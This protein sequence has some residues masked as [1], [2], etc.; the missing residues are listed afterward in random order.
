MNN[1]KYLGY[2]IYYEINDV[3]YLDVN[4][5]HKDYYFHEEKID[6]KKKVREL[7]RKK[8]ERIYGG[9]EECNNIQ[10]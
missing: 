4:Y 5:Y 9:E 3:G 1:K 8:L 7:R 2:E 6:E 10:V